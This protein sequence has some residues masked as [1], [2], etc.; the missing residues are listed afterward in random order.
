MRYSLFSLTNLIPVA[1]VLAFSVAVTPGKAQ[2]IGEYGGLMGAPKH[3][4]FNPNAHKTL[5]N[6]YTAPGRAAAGATSGS[7]QA[8]AGVIQSGDVTSGGGVARAKIMQL[9]ADSQKAYEQG[10]KFFKEGNFKE[11]EK[12]FNYSLKVREAYWKNRDPLIPKIYRALADIYEETGKTPEKEKALNEM[13]ASY[14]RIKGP[15]TKE[16]IE[17]LKE[18]G[19][20]YGARGELWPSHDSYEQALILAERY[21]GKD[22]AQAVE[23][24][25]R[26]A[27]KLKDLNKLDRSAEAF[28]AALAI[29]DEKHYVAGTDLADSLDDYAQ[30]LRQL[31]KTDEADKLAAR[32]SELRSK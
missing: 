4:P 11:A 6:V 2:G 13:L 20:I 27:A 10:Q 29:N 9:S 1:L 14:A 7:S 19:D 3:I 32:A 28:K 12:F 17:P 26:M 22:S 18:L 23:L 30:V 25:L 21:D 16:R 24:K 15:G 5:H 8:S 31:K